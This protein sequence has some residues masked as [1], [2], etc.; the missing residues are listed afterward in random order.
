MA[1]YET[2]GEEPHSG[3]VTDLKG[4]QHDLGHVSSIATT[5]DAKV[6]IGKAAFAAD[7]P[8][9][10]KISGGF[11]F[12]DKAPNFEA[13]LTAL[14]HDAG[15]VSSV[16]LRGARPATL[17]LTSTEAAAD[18][19]ILGKIDSPYVLD[20]TS[21]N[22]TLTTGHGSKLIIRD[23][24]GDDTITRGRTSETF[25]FDKGFGRA[26]VTDASRHWKGTT[27]DV[28]D[29]ATSEFR[30]FAALLKDATFAGGVTTITTGDDRLVLDGFSGKSAFLAGDRLGDFKFF[31]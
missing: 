9:L 13:E 21:A 16:I 20:V 30:N 31:S 8:I 17:S 5:G 3:L 12:S 10:N 2:V 4:L 15:H 25:V 11:V 23:A 19:T 24:A 14:E 7:E 22:R 26:T 18:E 27:H 6:T 29:F 1:P 28:A